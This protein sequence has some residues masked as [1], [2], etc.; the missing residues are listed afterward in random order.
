MK[1][2]KRVDHWTSGTVRECS[3]I[4]GSPQPL[5]SAIAFSQT[6]T[7]VTVTLWYHFLQKVESQERTLYQEYHLSETNKYEMVN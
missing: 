4:A 1:G 7:G 6:R 3:E 5:L 2:S